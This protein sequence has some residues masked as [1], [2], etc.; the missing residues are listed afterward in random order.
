MSV[1]LIPEIPPLPAAGPGFVRDH[2][3]FLIPMNRSILIILPGIIPALIT[4]RF[5]L[6]INAAG[7]GIH[8]K[9]GVNTGRDPRMPAP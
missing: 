4:R 6:L 3:D 7:I 1:G 5:P 8:M 2:R 9:G